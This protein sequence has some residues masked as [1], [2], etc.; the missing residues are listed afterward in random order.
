MFVL[1]ELYGAFAI[2]KTETRVS[3]EVSSWIHK[4]GAPGRCRV[5]RSVSVVFVYSL[6]FFVERCADLRLEDA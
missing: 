2:L 3:M 6:S 1:K 4:S 5:S